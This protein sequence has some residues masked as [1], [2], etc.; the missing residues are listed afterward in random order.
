MANKTELFNFEINKFFNN[1]DENLSMFC[2]AL[3][4]HKSS[5]ELQL[6][7]NFLLNQCESITIDIEDGYDVSFHSNTIKLIKLCLDLASILHGS[8]KSKEFLLN[9]KKFIQVFLI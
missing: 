2:V 3:S 7:L 8:F 4:S 1:Y 5:T 6:L 9:F